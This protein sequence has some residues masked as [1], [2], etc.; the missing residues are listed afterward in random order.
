M[1]DFLVFENIGFVYPSDGFSAACDE[2][3]IPT[4]AVDVELA[5][6]FINYLYDPDVAARNIEYICC[7]MPNKPALE[8]IP[9]ELKS[10]PAVIPPTHIISKA[11]VLEDVGDAVTLYT[12]VWDKIKAAE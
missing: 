3:V 6:A 12:K 1:S 2:M 11:E 4:D 10:N 5:H 8:R 9:E 7:V